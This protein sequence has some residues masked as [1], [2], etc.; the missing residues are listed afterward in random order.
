MKRY[1]VN[2]AFKSQGMRWRYAGK[3]DDWQSVVDE[4]HKYPTVTADAIRIIDTETNEVIYEE[5]K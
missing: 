5:Y 4:F 3:V 1:K 2:K